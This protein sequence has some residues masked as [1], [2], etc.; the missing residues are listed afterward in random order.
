MTNN[1]TEPDEDMRS[2]V[3][4]CLDSVRGDFYEEYASR[5]NSLA[6]VDFD[7]C[8]AAS[9]W[10][11][12]SHAS[13]LTGTLPHVHGV[14]THNRS[15]S[16]VDVSETFLSELRDYRTVGISSNVWA[17]SA[18][19][20]DRYFDEFYEIHEMCRFPDGIDMREFVSESDADGFRKYAEILL[21]CVDHDNP[22][23]SFANAALA[24]VD[25]L[26]RNLPIPKLLDDGAKS[27]LRTAKSEVRAADGPYFLFLNI[28][29]PHIALY[30]TWW[31]DDSLYSVPNT[32]SSDEYSVWELNEADDYHEEYWRRRRELYGAVIDYVDRQITEFIEEVRLV[33]GSDVSFVITAD[34]GD[35]LGTKVDE[36]LANH[37]CSLSEGLLHV[38]LQI[39]DPPT[40]FETRTDR[41]V[42]HLELGEIVVSLANG[43]SHDPTAERIP[44]ELM[45]LSAGPD[46]DNDIDHWDRMQRCAYSG[47]RKYVWDSNGDSRV[48][49][50]NFDIRCWQ[51]ERGEEIEIPEWCRIMFET[52][53]KEYKRD[54]KL[55]TRETNVDP[56]TAKRLKDLGYI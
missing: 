32:W 28:M 21:R 14:H 34:H 5:L 31:Y 33:S 16:G 36:S 51:S 22:L 30:P 37:K 40:D 52:D 50:L 45:G 18:F 35:N 12:P 2:V 15:F 55:A 7:Q 44:A 43:E 20:F 53:I 27:V 4:I 56:G 3:L 6:E 13:M 29:D 38:P 8:R 25:S 54:A 48:Y 26:T 10:S 9:S 23:K 41:Y 46:P 1:A 47:E 42:S 24:Q 49:E 39:I 19:G 17:S 11:T